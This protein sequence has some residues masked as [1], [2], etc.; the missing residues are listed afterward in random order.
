MTDPR[1]RRAAM[2]VCAAARDTA[3]A[4]LLLDALGLVEAGS[5]AWPERGA[6]GVNGMQ[7]LRVGGD[8]K[9]YRV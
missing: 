6:L 8:G 2:Y 7:M 5:L 9:G 1:A 3:D 4:A